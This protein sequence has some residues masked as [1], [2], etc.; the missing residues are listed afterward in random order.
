MKTFVDLYQLLQR[1]LMHRFSVARQTTSQ[2]VN[3]LTHQDQQ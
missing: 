1:F 3:R 2:N